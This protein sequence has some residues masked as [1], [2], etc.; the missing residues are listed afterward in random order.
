MRA[1]IV[2]LRWI[3]LLCLLSEVGCKHHEPYQG[4]N[5]LD[6]QIVVHETP[7]KPLP[8]D[9]VVQQTPPTPPPKQ[10][11]MQE[12][13]PAAELKVPAVQLEPVIPSLN[14]TINQ[15]KFEPKRMGL[16]AAYEN[17]LDHRNDDAVAAIK[18]YPT[19]DQDIAL[20][21]LPLLARIDQG[22][23]YTTMNGTQK[24][25]VLESLRG[26][27][28]RLSKSAP[29]VLQHMTLAKESAPRFGE[30]VPRRNAVYQIEDLVFLY[31][32]ISNL[33]DYPNSEG[34]YNIRL[35][36]TLELIGPD[37]KVA[38]NDSKA[39]E[40][41]GS[42]SSRNDYHISAWF[43]LVRQLQPGN[44]TVSLTVLDRDTNRTTKQSLPLQILES[45]KR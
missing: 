18:H 32:E 42:I 33:L 23:S 37:G 14:N 10:L 4:G 31:A 5:A 9:L 44:Y 39:F 35:D 28:R 43:T 16:I 7:S 34:L 1:A 22:E 8:V 26:M 2:S 41:K 45:K 17:Y 3:I 40:K 27:L 38:W 20:I 36:V 29:L 13:V 21:T 6:P 11:A 15:A 24:L 12:T 25:A 30:V 19:D